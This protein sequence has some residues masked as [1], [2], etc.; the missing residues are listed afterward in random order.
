[1]PNG[2][3]ANGEGQSTT[4]IPSCGI[5]DVDVAVFN[6]FDQEIPFTA[7]GPTV[8]QGSNQSVNI[9][10]PTVI[11]ATGE[12]FAVVKKLKPVRDRNGA[13]MLPA[14]SIRRTSVDQ[15]Y[16]DMNRRAMSQGA[17]EMTIKRKLDASDR[18]YQN[19]INKLNLKNRQT[20]LATR[21][22]TG[23]EKNE[24]YV[25]QGLLLA[26]KIGDNVYEV[27]SIPTP[28]FINV[29]YEVVFWAGFTPQMNY[30]IETLLSSQLPQGK[31]FKVTTSGGYWF[32]ANLGDE[33][34]TQG[35]I[36][37]FTEEERILKYSFS[38][39]V[40]AFVIPGSQPGVPISVKSYISA[41]QF[42]FTS[43]EEPLEKESNIEKYDKPNNERFVLSNLEEDEKTQQQPTTNQRFLLRRVDVDPRTGKEIVRYI[44]IKHRNAKKGTTSYVASDPKIL[45]E[46]FASIKGKR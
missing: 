12:R 43:H 17:G 7:A 37:D 32:L 28:Q 24:S 8:A 30:M 13:L 10:K 29:K 33:F 39:S 46:Y 1:M 45:E 35:N 5:E 22:N 4:T 25:G 3:V 34:Q 40:E 15:S 20:D 19:L 9:K 31:Y 18:E 21:R 16:D 38:I 36:E 23:E 6:L 14:I 42:E 26:P 44:K 11:F 41:T 27:I 2:Y